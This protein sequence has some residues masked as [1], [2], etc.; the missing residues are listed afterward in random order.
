MMQQ[1]LNSEDGTVPLIFIVHDVE[2][3]ILKTAL[4]VLIQNQ[5]VAS[6]DNVLRVLNS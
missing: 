2:K 5:S 3:S 4:D 6:V 1:A